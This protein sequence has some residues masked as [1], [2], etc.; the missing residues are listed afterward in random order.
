MSNQPTPDRPSDSFDAV[1][2]FAVLNSHRVDYVLVGGYAA[3]L[4]GASRPT[5]DAVVTP[6]TGVD[7]L[8]RLSAALRELKARIRTDAVPEGLPFNTSAE[9]L[10]GMK[11]LNLQ[12]EHGDLDLTFVPDGTTGYRDL[13]R[14]ATAE[15]VGGTVVQVAALIDIIRSK[16]AAG[17]QKDIEALPELH[18]LAR[19]AQPPAAGV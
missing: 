17:R 4:R 9:A 12:T 6:E 2:I 16:T 7:N 3:Q 14:S 5:T 10:Q 18:A 19:R 1:S 8:A 15:P 13:I 11:T